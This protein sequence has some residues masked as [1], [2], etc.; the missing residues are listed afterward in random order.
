MKFYNNALEHGTR[1][2]QWVEANIIPVPKKGDLTDTANY[3]GIALSS[4]TAKTLNRMTLNRIRPHIEAI[5]RIN[6]NGFVKN[7]PPPA[8]L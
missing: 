1:P 7:A 2:D 4:I 6:Q 3:R 8:T 5:L